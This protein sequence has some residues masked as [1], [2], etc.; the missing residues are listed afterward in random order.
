[1]HNTSTMSAWFRYTHGRF[2]STLTRCW[3]HILSPI[4]CLPKMDHKELSRAPER[5]TK[6]NERILPILTFREGREQH[7]PDSS[8]HSLFM[9]KLFNSSSPE[10]NC[11]E[12][13]ARQRSH[14][15]T[16]PHDKRKREDK[17][18]RHIQKHIHMRF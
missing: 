7:I 18:E 6:R 4:S 8:D 12:C 9:I 3:C 14:T 11:A 16:T 1:M 5:F 13:A 10:G 15:H 17:R 2:E